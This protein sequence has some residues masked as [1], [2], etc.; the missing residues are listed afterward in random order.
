MIMKDEDL[1]ASR[2]ILDAAYQS[3]K[4][5]AEPFAT[6]DKAWDVYSSIE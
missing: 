4:V 6:P 3:L 2:K 1:K 5:S